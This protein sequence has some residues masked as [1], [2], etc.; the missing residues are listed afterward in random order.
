MSILGKGAAALTSTG[1]DTYQY[2]LPISGLE[3]LEVW[4]V[5]GPALLQLN[6]PAAAGTSHLATHRWL[7]GVEVMFDDTSAPLVFAVTGIP[8]PFVAPS[9]GLPRIDRLGIDVRDEDTNPNDQR[10][11]RLLVDGVDH[12]AHVLVE[13]PGDGVLRYVFTSITLPAGKAF[14]NLSIETTDASGNRHTVLQPVQVKYRPRISARKPAVVDTMRKGSVAS[15]ST[16]TWKIG[17][18]KLTLQ[19]YRNG[20]PIKRATKAKLSL[21]MMRIGDRIHCKVTATNSWGSSSLDAYSRKVVPV[22]RR[23]R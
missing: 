19:W 1:P 5:D 13:Q 14:V 21:G 8:S 7:T 16:G 11:V 12:G 18:G 17:F 3:L 2:G 4:P 6:A 10:T 15:C 9:K 23:R 20:R 22:P